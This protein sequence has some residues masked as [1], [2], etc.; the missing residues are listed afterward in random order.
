M[1]AK[2]L[3]ATV[4]IALAVVG[5]AC[6]GGTVTVSISPPAATV[7]AGERQAFVAMVTGASDTAVTWS[8]SEGASGG[9]IDANG[10]YTAPE[11]AGIF[12]VVATSRA[13]PSKSARAI[14]T[15]VPRSSGVSISV[16]P[17]NVSLAPLASHSFTSTVTGTDNL[18]VTWTVEEGAAGGSVD[19]TGRYT[20]P[21]SSGTFHVVAT[22]Q[23]DPSKSARATVTVVEGVA[24]SVSP[25]AVTL[26]PGQTQDF[27]ATVTG[28]SNTAVT[29]SVQ[30]GPDGGTVTAQGLYTAPQKLGTYHVVATSVAD[31]SRQAVATVTVESSITVAISPASATVKTGDYEVFTATVTGTSNQAV[32]WSVVE[33]AA[34]GSISSS[35]VYFAP[36][37]PGTYTVKATSQEDPSRSATAKVTAVQGVQV[38]VSPS[39]VTL[40]TGQSQT[41]TAVVTGTSNQAV[42]WSVGAAGGSITSA[43]V[44]TAPA[45][46]GTYQVK[47]TSVDDP[48]ESG[49]ASVTVL[50]APVTVSGTVQYGGSKTGRIYVTV[51]KGSLILG[52]SLASPGGF[53][54]RG[55]REYG[56]YTVR[57]FMDALGNASGNEAYNPAA[58]TTFH[59]SGQ[60]VTNLYLVLHDPAPRTPAAPSPPMIVPGNEAA[61]VFWSSVADSSGESADH[62]RVYWSTNHSP[63]TTNAI[64]SKSFRANSQRVGYIPG[65]TNGATLYFAIA[66]VNH[67]V[68]GPLS[69]PVGPFTIGAPLGG[70]AL[71]GTVSFPGATPSG[72]LLVFAVE[73]AY[74][75]LTGTP[76]LYFTQIDAPSSSQ[77][78]T[79]TGLSQGVHGLV[80]FLDQDDDGELGRMDPSNM[81]GS[82]V[83]VS[84]TGSSTTAPSISLGATDGVALALTSHEVSSAGHEY[85]LDLAVSGGQKWPVKVALTGGPHVSGTYD[86][87]LGPGESPYQFN[88]QLGS[89][90]PQAGDTYSF[91]VT[92]SDGSTG[93]LTATVSRLLPTPTLISPLGTGGPKPTF[94]WSNAST[95]PT[96]LMQ[97]LTVIWSQS[98]WLRLGLP[99]QQTSVVYNDDGS[100]PTPSLPIGATPSWTVTVQDGEGNRAS[101][102]ATFKVQ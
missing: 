71:T 9:A 57:A 67:G 11:R 79:L 40:S 29:W 68:E 3:S 50:G 88:V 94:Q 63:S 31:P 54:I 69:T 83:Y 75:S 35:G 7:A 97:Y 56:E 51:S 34:G 80:A 72:P 62:Y 1:I 86:L 20:A 90:I 96:N 25:S 81:P 15:V 82:V 6:P 64:G 32:T 74:Q 12:H 61:A 53:S 21:A 16:T 99:R 66:G 24:V 42:T 65:L 36:S 2:L 28:S 101:T 30:E 58:E 43:G 14:V 100:A 13:D 33:G 76:K 77:A 60:A 26:Q 102:T 93:T 19:A 47:A 73:Y 4:L 41:F 55:V 84:V 22:S 45:T 89:S 44:Y 85:G 27:A 52:T 98:Y 23:A 95:V 48:G 59:Y 38:Q 70:S 5:M 49:F 37:T 39:S 17:A 46:P 92:Y 91:D 10:Q 87:G 78:F 18:A 8:I